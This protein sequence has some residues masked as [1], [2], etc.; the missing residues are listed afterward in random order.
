M[1][2]KLKR[3]LQRME[4][5][6]MSKKLK[7]IGDSLTEKEIDV[8]SETAKP[9]DVTKENS[10]ITAII[11]PVIVSTEPKKPV[12]S[13]KVFLNIFGKKWDQ[14]AGFKHYAMKNGLEPLTVEEW[15]EAFQNFLDRPTA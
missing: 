10:E 3:T 15:R 9:V 1:L 2:G 12:V 14:M 13:L 6:K 5:G 7:T 8:I 11:E 4:L